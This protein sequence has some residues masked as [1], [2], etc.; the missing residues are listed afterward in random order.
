MEI[1]YDRDVL[2]LTPGGNA[3]ERHILVAFIQAAARCFSDTT[4]FWAE[5][6]G[7]PLEQVAAQIGDK[8]KFEN[9]VRAKLMKRGGVGYLEPSPETFPFSGICQSA[10]SSLRRVALCSLAGRYF[11]GRAGD[12]GA[13]WTCLSARAW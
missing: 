5:K 6:L 4:P 13:C 8:S 10:Y 1:D 3:T 7:L 9:L 2:P 12:R 11:G